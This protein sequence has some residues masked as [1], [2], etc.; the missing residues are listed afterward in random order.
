[1]ATR[2]P[3]SQSPADPSTSIETKPSASDV[4]PVVPKWVDQILLLAILDPIKSINGNSNPKHRHVIY[5]LL[6]FTVA[7]I[8]T[9]IGMYFVTVDFGGMLYLPGPEAVCSRVYILC[10]YCNADITQGPLLSGASR[11]P[12]RPM[13]SSSRISGWLGRMTRRRERRW[14]GRRRRRRSSFIF[15]LFFSFPSFHCW[16]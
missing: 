5:K 12:L 4:S 15:A 6:G 1:M 11:R 16:F 8:T 2:R 14:R 13:W 9:P 7:M 10:M 3:Q